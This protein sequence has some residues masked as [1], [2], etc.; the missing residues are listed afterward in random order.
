MAA[1]HGDSSIERRHVRLICTA[2]S[3]SW[4]ALPPSRR[5]GAAGVSEG[6]INWLEF[7][8]TEILEEEW[9]LVTVVAEALVERGTLAR[10]QFKMLVTQ[11]AQ[12]AVT[13]A[14]RAEA[15]RQ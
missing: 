14:P 3:M 10:K 11:T 15:I 12:R 6:R 9:T 8:A 2:V 13:E 4:S 5:I 1:S 7:R